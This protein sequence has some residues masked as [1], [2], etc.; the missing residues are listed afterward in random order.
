MADYENIVATVV[1]L[2][3]KEYDLEPEALLSSLREKGPSEARQIA[4]LLLRKTTVM[5]FPELGR[6]FGGRD[7]TTIISAVKT[8]E[9][10]IAT[11]E[12]A[13]RIYERVLD[14]VTKPEFT[15]ATVRLYARLGL[16]NAE[17]AR[18]AV[19][20]DRLEAEIDRIGRVAREA[21]AAE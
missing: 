9:K 8:A 13:A 3:A 15:E 14:I 16:V 1:R 5:S 11:D 21:E 2:V 4:C 12:R 10:R 18:L 7:H 6:A 17:L 19:E 20:R